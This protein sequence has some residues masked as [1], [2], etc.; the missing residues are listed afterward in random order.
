MSTSDSQQNNLR[1]KTCL[2]IVT[3]VNMTSK[4]AFLKKINNGVTK[5][6]DRKKGFYLNKIIV[7]GV[8]LSHRSPWIMPSSKQK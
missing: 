4:R 6:N 8:F 5:V 7:F 2:I 1:R 3:D